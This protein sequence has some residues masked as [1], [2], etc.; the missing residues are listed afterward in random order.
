ME[1][2]RPD[3]SARIPGSDSSRRSRPGKGARSGVFAC[4]FW[5]GGV[6]YAIDAV[7][8]AEVLAVPHLVPVPQTPEWLLGLHNLRG[9]A[10]GVIDFATVMSLPGGPPPPPGAGI[11]VLV[12]KVEGIMLGARIDRIEAVYPFDSARFE[13]TAGTA[14]HPAVRGVLEFKARGGFSATL[15]GDQELGARVR[16]LPLRQRREGDA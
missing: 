6:R 13:A 12:L 5:I 11:V 14:E 4:V 2:P 8:V 3:D 10:L 7:H 1:A 9:T 15:L 16:A